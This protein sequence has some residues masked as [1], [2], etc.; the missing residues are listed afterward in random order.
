MDNWNKKFQEVSFLSTTGVNWYKSSAT[1][2]G[3]KVLPLVT[4]RS[5]TGINGKNYSITGVKYPTTGVVYTVFFFNR[6]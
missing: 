2:I 5:T 4:K 6:H 1:G 3:V